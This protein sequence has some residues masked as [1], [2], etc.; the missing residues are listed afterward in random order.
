MGGREDDFFEGFAEKK[1]FKK[2]KADLSDKN[3]K[4]LCSIVKA[5]YPKILPHIKEYG[6]KEKENVLKRSPIYTN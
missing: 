3:M 6:I 1:I 5:P 2:A 4:I